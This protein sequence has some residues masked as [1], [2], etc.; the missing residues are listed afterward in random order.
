[1]THETRSGDKLG[2]KSDGGGRMSG[3]TDAAK[4]TAS[5]AQH[6]VQEKTAGM[7][8]KAQEATGQMQ[9][10]MGD[11]ADEAR[12]RAADTGERARSQA[13]QI[14]EQRKKSLVD[15]GRNVQ[16]EAEKV[17]DQLRSDGMDAPARLLETAA[18]QVE[19]VISYVDRTP[20]DD[21]VSDAGRAARRNPFTFMGA[22]FALGFASTRLLKAGQSGDGDGG[23]SYQAR[24]LQPAGAGTFATSEPSDTSAYGSRP[25]AT[26][27]H[28][29][30]GAG[31]GGGAQAPSYGTTGYGSPAGSTPPGAPDSSEPPRLRR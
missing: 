15:Q 28:A 8:H 2:K 3:A 19:G 13:F 24:Q 16:H 21:I 30:I 7:Q 20:V 1:M 12:S 10:R 6:K 4:D 26:T 11:V 29:D 17:A 18:S 22:A 23:S 27:G 25:G 9:H 14:A 31:P 5:K